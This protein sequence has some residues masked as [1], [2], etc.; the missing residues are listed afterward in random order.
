MFSLQQNWRIGE[1]RTGSAL[2]GVGPGEGR[3]EVI[4]T[5][6]TYV[7]KYKNEKGVGL[8]VWLK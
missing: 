3:M 8:E 2:K 5:K 1:G 4:Q 6:Y 7:S